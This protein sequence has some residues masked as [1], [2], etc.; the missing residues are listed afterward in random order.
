MPHPLTPDTLIYGFT[1]AGDPQISPDGTRI[2]YSLSQ[3]NRDTK[4]PSSN[5]WLCDVDGSNPRQLTQTSGRNGGGRWSP[6]GSR[7]AFVSDRVKKSGIFVL[8]ALASGEAR[9]ITHHSAS[10]TD[11]AWSS[12]GTR[13]AY[14]VP[15]DPAN[16]DESEPP[17][18]AAPRVRVTR[19]IDYKQDN[20]G[21]LGDTRLQVFVVDVATGERRRVTREVVDYSVP[22]WSPDGMWLAAQVP[23]RNTMYSQLALI[24]VATG[25]TC[26]IGSEDGVAGTWAWSPSGDHILIAGD[27]SQSWQLDLFLYDVASGQTRR[28]TED[29]QCAPDTGYSNVIPPAQ[30]IWLDDR[31]ALFHAIQSGASGLYAIDTQTGAIEQVQHTQA[32][33]SGLSMDATRRYAV[34]SHSRLDAIGE[35]SVFDRVSGETRILTRYGE[36]VLREHPAATWER[37]DVRRGDFTTEAWLLKPP[38]FDPS[39]RYPVILD[40]HG[41]PNSY[42]GYGFNLVQQCLASHDFLVVF[43]NP[44]G[45][46]S[47]GRHFTQQVIHDWGGEDYLDLMTLMDAVLERPYA[48]AERTGIYGYSYGG[49]MTA[50]TIGHTQRFKAA[51]CG[52]PCFDLESFYGTSDIGLSFGDIQ[53]G[54]EPH[55]IREWYAAHSPSNFAHQTRTPTLIVQGEADERCPIGQGEQMFITLKKAGCEVEFARYPGGS[56][57]MLRVGPPEHRADFLTRVLGWFQTHLGEPR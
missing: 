48:D 33:N 5:L 52:A 20:R 40:V 35:I 57:A 11:L 36:P 37:L 55:A 12:D 34:Q 56:H 2:L 29:L 42:Y 14:T 18:G 15:F 27:T 24:E 1:L 51:V 4:K 30:P 54:G 17:E 43:S 10:I 23:N 25:E 16:P 26:L 7:I 6:D 45:S 53:F 41:G 28:L 50:W 46:G 32:L 8:P 31:H 49:F 47:Y 44:R 39:R 3:T 38:N 21:Y 22:Q 9:E 19:R 13:L